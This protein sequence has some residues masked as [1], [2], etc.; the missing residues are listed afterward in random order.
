L[1]FLLC[2]FVLFVCL[3]AFLVWVGLFSE[4]RAETGTQQEKSVRKESGDSKEMR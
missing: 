1:F 4:D 2:L 3:F